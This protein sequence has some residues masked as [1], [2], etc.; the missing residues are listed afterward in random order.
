MSSSEENKTVGLV[1]VKAE[2]AEAPATEAPVVEAP[3]VEAPVVEAVAEAPVVEAPVVEAPAVEAPVAEAPVAEAVAVEAP[4]VVNDILVTSQQQV[5]ELTELQQKAIAS[6]IA[7]VKEVVGEL[8]SN[9]FAVTKV[10]SVLMK[11]V[12]TLQVDGRKLN[13]ADKKKVVLEA[14]KQ[15]LSSKLSNDSSIMQLYNALAEPTIEAMID[16]SRGVNFAT[17]AMNIISDNEVHV[18]VG[19]AARKCLGFC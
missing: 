14:G 15:V 19:N 9:A 13:G 7:E 18:A 11:K 17:V 16:M 3:V 5:S 12:E 4:A 1:E 10:I 6:L 2:V 8:S